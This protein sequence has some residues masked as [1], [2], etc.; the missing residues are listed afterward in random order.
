MKRGELSTERL[1]AAAI[2]YRAIFDVKESLDWVSAKLRFSLFS[3][4]FKSI[5]ERVLPWKKGAPRWMRQTLKEKRIIVFTLNVPALERMVEYK[6]GDYCAEVY[7]FKTIQEL[8]H[9]MRVY[10]SAFTVYSNDPQILS[11]ES[12]TSSLRYF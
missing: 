12:N 1:S 7:H 8:R 9:W 10:E 4:R 5:S 6:V 11:M 2:D 3:S